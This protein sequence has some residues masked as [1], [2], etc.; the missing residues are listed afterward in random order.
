MATNVS[1]EWTCGSLSASATEATWQ[2]AYTEL[3]VDLPES[4]VGHEA[5]HGAD[6][7]VLHKAVGV[8]HKLQD[9]A[10]APVGLDINLHA[11]LVAVNALE[12]AA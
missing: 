10:S 8:L 6:A 3:P 4:F 2:P 5:I 9:Y 11:A 1:L 12:I 7:L